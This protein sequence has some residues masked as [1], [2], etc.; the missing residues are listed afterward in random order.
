MKIGPPPERTHCPVAADAV[1]DYEP[2]GVFADKSG[3]VGEVSVLRCRWCGIGISMP[4]LADVAF[5]YEGR[6]SQDFQPSTRGLAHWIKA[7]VFRR[8]ARDLLRQIGGMPRRVLDFGCGSGQFTRC[9]SDELPDADVIGSDFHVDPPRDLVDRPYLSLERLD[10]EKGQFDLVLAMHVLE[11]DDDVRG[12]LARI[13][14][15]VQPGG[16]IV[17]EVPN[18]DCVWS[19]LIGAS[20]DSWYLPFHRTHFSRLSLRA[21]LER[22]GLTVVDERAVCLP[23]MGRTLA[24]V[25]GRQN[26]LAFLLAGIALHPLQWLGERLTRQPSALRIIARCSDI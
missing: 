21:H 7:H 10:A 22:Q 9:L 11:H 5:L 6:E 2:L 19:K 20:W 17:V 8:Q 25:F 15:M 23:T 13:V 14:A 26:N 3:R 18:I 1:C 12:L 24:N 4:R 16:T